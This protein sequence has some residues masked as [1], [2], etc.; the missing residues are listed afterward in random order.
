M[1]LNYFHA[2][3][4]CVHCN[5]IN[6]ENSR[7]VEI[8][9]TRSGP[10]FIHYCSPSVLSVINHCHYLESTVQQSP[11]EYTYPINMKVIINTTLQGTDQKDASVQA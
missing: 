7:M 1:S 4:S 9:G 2:K 11:K 8:S 5:D 10:L 6:S 3:H